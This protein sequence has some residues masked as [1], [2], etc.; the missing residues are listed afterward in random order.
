MEKENSESCFEEWGCQINRSALIVII[1]LLPLISLPSGLAQPADSSSKW[2]QPFDTPM[3]LLHSNGGTSYDCTGKAQWN[4]NLSLED[5]KWILHPNIVEF[6][7]VPRKGDETRISRYVIDKSMGLYHTPREVCS[8][9]D[10]VNT[11]AW[12]DRSLYVLQAGDFVPLFDCNCAN[13]CDKSKHLVWDGYAGCSCICEDG[14]KFDE[15][16]NCVMDTSERGRRS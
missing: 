8:V 7:D 1:L 6:I 3:Y 5:P 4:R 14:W 12:L 9:A 13:A 15:H 10:L 16:G 11:P 2:D